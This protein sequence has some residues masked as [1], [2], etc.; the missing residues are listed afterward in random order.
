MS[1]RCRC[2]HTAET[3]LPGIGCYAGA[4]GHDHCPCNHYSP[5]VSRMGEEKP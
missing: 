3:H 5:D 1:R 2:G 4:S